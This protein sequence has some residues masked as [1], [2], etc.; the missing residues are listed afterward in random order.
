[1]GKGEYFGGEVSV[2]AAYSRGGRKMIM[3]AVL[4]D[5]AGLTHD[6]AHVTVPPP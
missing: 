6:D 2:S 1:L 4:L 3:F 5:R